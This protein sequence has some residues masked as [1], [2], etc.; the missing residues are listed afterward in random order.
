MVHSLVNMVQLMCMRINCTRCVSIMTMEARRVLPTVKSMIRTTITQQQWKKNTIIHVLKRKYQRHF[1][2]QVHRFQINLVLL[3]TYTAEYTKYRCWS[4][5]SFHTYSVS[6]GKYMEE[7]KYSNMHNVET[8][9]TNCHIDDHSIKTLPPPPPPSAQQQQQYATTTTTNL[10][11]VGG[12]H[13]DDVSDN[14]MTIIKSEEANVT[15]SYILPP[16]LH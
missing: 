10:A 3:Y 8:K 12:C 14:G 11:T 16:F 2:I 9:Y 13:T 4:C 7:M 15:H 5:H 1:L 6:N